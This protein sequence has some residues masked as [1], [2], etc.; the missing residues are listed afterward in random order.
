MRDRPTNTT[1]RAT[2]NDAGRIESE[3]T[4]ESSGSL[5]RW[6]D[7]MR[8]QDVQ[9]VERASARVSGT[10]TNTYVPLSAASCCYHHA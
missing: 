10:L 8:S 2:A 9:N 7:G 5:S 3:C 1:T 6:L 4:M